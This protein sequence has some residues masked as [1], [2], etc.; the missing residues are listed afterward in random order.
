L[1]VYTDE[2]V[3]V[4]SALANGMNIPIKKNIKSQDKQHCST[5]RDTITMKMTNLQANSTQP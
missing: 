2:T 3:K 4:A 5:L 1:L